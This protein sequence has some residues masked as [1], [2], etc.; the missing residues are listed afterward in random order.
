MKRHGS[1]LQ[2]DELNDKSPH[3]TIDRKSALHSSMEFNKDLKKE[4]KDQL[5]FNLPFHQGKKSK[6]E[7]IE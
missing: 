7:Q 1:D 2:K 3:I 6:Q 5:M 4:R